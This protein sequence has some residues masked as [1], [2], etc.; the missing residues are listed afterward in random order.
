[1]GL[2]TVHGIVHEHRGHVMVESTPGRGSVFRVLLPP[3]DPGEGIGDSE[4][5]RESPP[6]TR[7]RLSG[8]VL[9]VDDEQMVAEYMGELLS[10]WGLRVTVMTDP[11]QAEAWYLDDPARVD[12]VITDQ[13]MPHRTGLEFARRITLQRP[14]LPVL[15]YTGYD[16]N[17]KSELLAA[18]G[19]VGLLRKPFERSEL[20]SLLEQH[21]TQRAH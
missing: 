19:V 21:L 2:A 1:M 3:L 17:L 7:R 12:L 18:A 8:T 20:F 14:E 6:R 5:T 9:V 13:T 4:A 10:G 16:E 15:L 11:D